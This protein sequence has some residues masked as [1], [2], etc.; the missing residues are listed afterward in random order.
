MSQTGVSV[1]SAVCAVIA[2]YSDTATV[3]LEQLRNSFL[4]EFDMEE[5]INFASEL[6]Y[7]KWE[8]AH[9]IIHILKSIFVKDSN[10]GL[11]ICEKTAALST[12]IWIK[13]VSMMTSQRSSEIRRRNSLNQN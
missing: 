6:I 4:N 3:Q 9:K 10:Y 13:T 8:P 2:P 11:L 7:L 12:Y 5:S 1:Q